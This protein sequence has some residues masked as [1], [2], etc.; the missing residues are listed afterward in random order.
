[1]R[2]IRSQHAASKVCLVSALEL[3]LQKTC[4]HAPWQKH[5]KAFQFVGVQICRVLL[6]LLYMHAL[7]QEGAKMLLVHDKSWRPVA[8]MCTHHKPKYM[9]CRKLSMPNIIC[10]NFHSDNVFGAQHVQN[11]SPKI[12]LDKLNGMS[13]WPAESQLSSR[14]HAIARFWPK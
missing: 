14:E 2:V 7:L 4:T 6:L 1:M 13:R 10:V 9:T 3:T 12:A 11:A 8:A 5:H